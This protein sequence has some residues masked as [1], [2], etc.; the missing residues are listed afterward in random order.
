MSLQ[1]SLTTLLLVASTLPGRRT[2]GTGVVESDHVVQRVVE[3]QVVGAA[4]FEPATTRTPSVCATRLRHAPSV[5][6]CERRTR[7]MGHLDAQQMAG[8]SAF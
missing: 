3:R 8:G 6:G 2:G 4:G 1:L 5:R 7:T